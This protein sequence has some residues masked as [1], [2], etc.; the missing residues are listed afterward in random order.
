[1]VGNESLH[2]ASND[3]GVRVEIFATSEDL[4]VKSTTFA[5]RSNRKHTLTSPDGV[6]HN[7]IMS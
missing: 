4:I 3:S 1:M 2:E 7:Q 6:T 5:H